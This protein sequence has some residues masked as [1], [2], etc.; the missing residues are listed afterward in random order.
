MTSNMG[1]TG[2]IFPGQG[3]IV[4]LSL[5]GE[6]DN[7]E[8]FSDQVH[9]ACRFQLV[10]DFLQGMMKDDSTIIILPGSTLKKRK[11][12]DQE[13]FDDQFSGMVSKEGINSDELRI[14][15]RIMPS[16]KPG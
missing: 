5:D 3:N 8:A 1:L 6:F 7:P 10:D 4:S 2:C 16:P 14:A 15:P 12:T 13:E 11:K 9:P